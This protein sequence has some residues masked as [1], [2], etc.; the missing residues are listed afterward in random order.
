M[1]LIMGVDPG[2]SGGCA[3]L[4]P[5]GKPMYVVKFRGMTPTDVCGAIGC[6]REEIKMCF[7]ERVSSMPKQGVASTFKFGKH[8]GFLHGVITAHKIPVTHVV[9]FVW[10]KFL[11]CATKGDKNVTKRR[12][13]ELFPSLTI[14]HA[15]AD[16]LLIAE[17]GR[18]SLAYK[19]AADDL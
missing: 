17:Y 4:R 3:I 7:L 2:E 18:R 12:A 1:S 6:Y 9:P 14:I 19:E 16:A 10:Q 15:I 13:Q 8:Y 5:D 11:N